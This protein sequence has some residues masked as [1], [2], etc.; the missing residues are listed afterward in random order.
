MKKLALAALSALL[1]ASPAAA[2]VYLPPGVGLPA[3]SVIGNV[4][5]TP[6]DAVAVSISQL[7]SSMGFPSSSQACASHSWVNTVSLAGVIGCTQPAVGDISGFGTGVATALGINTGSGGA[8][9]INGGPLGAPASGNAGNLTNIPLGGI[10]GFGV[11][12][13]TFL[14]TPTSANLA[15]ALTDETGTGQAVFATSPTLVT[16]TIGAATATSVN[17]VAITAPASSATLT[18]ANGKTAAFSNTLTFAG[19]DS[20]TLNIGTGG[21][22][23]ASATTDTTNASNISSGTLGTARGGTGCDIGTAWTTS[24]PTPTPGGGSFTA[25]STVAYKQC[26]K[27]VYCRGTITISNAGTGTG[28]ILLQLP[29]TLNARITLGGK[30]VVVNGIMFS[31]DVSTAGVLTLLKYD[32]TTAIVTNGSFPFVFAAETP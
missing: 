12:V 6:G 26:G 3:Q 11:G 13:A 8:V 4:Q 22:L 14:G 24:T 16:P 31:A 18:I 17:K 29:F 30:E 7:K 23:A 2:Q 9:V 25:T 20:S 15:G 1:I 21:T 5:S 28:A 10:V 27:V 19:T 32:N